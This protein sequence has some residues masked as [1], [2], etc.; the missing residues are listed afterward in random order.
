MSPAWRAG[1]VGFVLGVAA[2]LGG[3]QLRAH[4]PAPA[5]PRAALGAPRLAAGSP[6]A[7]PE[8]FLGV[9]AA[10]QA[11][12]VVARGAGR[13]EAVNVALGDHVA[14]GDTVARVTTDLVRRDLAIARAALDAAH[15]DV[16]RWQVVERRTEQERQRRGKLP[17]VLSRADLDQAI[18]DRDE[19]VAQRKRAEAEV[20]RNLASIEG[21]KHLL[22]RAEVRAPFAGVVAARYLDPG[23]VVTPGTAVVRL[24][25][26]TRPRVRFAVPAGQAATIA[27]RLEVRFDLPAPEPIAI[28]V[29]EQ[30]AP[31]IDPASRTV[32]AEARFTAPPPAVAV[33]T[34]VR[35]SRATAANACSEGVP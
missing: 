21:L 14:A 13:L 10:E 32:F 34:A 8:C 5:S 35:V 1:L 31:E 30:I 19:A 2:A 28:G 29:V 22:A 9:V 25:S 7:E 24:I 11:A 6:S 15:A 18:A 20:A 16:E 12:D 27:A 4:A 3:L 17:E 26:D 23:S 33:G